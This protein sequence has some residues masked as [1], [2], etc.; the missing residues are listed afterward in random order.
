M[1][2]SLECRILPNLEICLPSLT[3][4][5]KKKLKAHLRTKHQSI[6]RSHDDSQRSR[7]LCN[8]SKCIGDIH[9][10]RPH[11]KHVR[12]AP[13]TWP[14][15]HTPKPHLFVRRRKANTSPG[16]T[17]SGK[18]ITWW[19][20]TV[21]PF[22]NETRPP[23]LFSVGGVIYTYYNHLYMLF[24]IQENRWQEA[25]IWQYLRISSFLPALAAVSSAITRLTPFLS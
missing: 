21:E 20:R 3:S 19:H 7:I 5:Q 8:L 6:S 9:H 12:K 16:S 2:L 13:E 24:E 18:T 25:M 14:K 4:N 10:F 23:C 11:K 17:P 22:K 15:N 1:A